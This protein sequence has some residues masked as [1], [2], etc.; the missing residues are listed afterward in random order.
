MSKPTISHIDALEIL[1]SRGNP[2][3][4]AVVT[5]ESG[6]QGWAAVPSG[7]STGSFEAIELRD[8][9]AKRYVGKGVQQ[10][11]SNVREKIAPKLKG[12]DASAQQKLDQTMLELDGTENKSKL[13][14]NAILAVSLASAQAAA[15]AS[16]LPLYHYLREQFFNDVTGWKLPV[17]M[18]N[19][20]NGGKHAI[21]SVDLQ[22]FMIMPY[23]ASSFSEGLRWGAEIYAHLKKIIHAKGW[24]VGI[25]DEG[26]FMPKLE[27]HK[28]AWELLVE[29]IEKAGY[30]PG[31]DVALAMDAAASEV[32]KDGEYV[33]KTEGKTLSSEG[34]FELYRAWAAEYPI[35]SIEDGFHEEDWSGYELMVREIGDDIQ[36][37]G[38]DLLVTNPKR[39][40]KAIKEKSAN[41]VLVKLNQIGSLTE[42][43]EVI[44]MA[45]EADFTAVISHRSGETEDTFIADLVVASNAGQI[46]SGAPARTDRVAKYNRLLRIEHELGSKAEY[47]EFPYK[48]KGVRSG[49]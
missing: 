19:V 25:G 26:G 1:D 24:A 31:V 32:F 46:K 47:A 33:L 4:E 14:A 11:V 40:A 38:D 9:D 17:P 8:D 35:V 48:V 42:T 6:E 21:G 28:Q 44:K 27:S 10:A 39:V 23:G 41:S 7:A 36:V 45:H 20:M 12:M 16:K 34:M 3:V 22:E 18:L 30:R 2:T 5:L 37:V 43:I 29:A 49:E 15:K 13:G